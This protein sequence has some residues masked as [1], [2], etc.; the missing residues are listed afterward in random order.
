M[1]FSRSVFVFFTIF[2][3][4]E[5]MAKSNPVPLIN[6]PLVPDSIA[7]GSKGFSLTINGTGFAD[8]AVVNWNGSQRLTQVIS[9]SKVKA[10]IK[11]SDVAKAGTA[12]VT[13]TNSGGATSNVVYFPIRKPA[14]K[15]AF[16]AD[17]KFTATGTIATGDF[18]NDGILDVAVGNGTTIDVYLGKGDGSFRNPIQSSVS[19]V[20]PMFYMVAADVNNDGN[21]DLIVSGGSYVDVAVLLGDGKGSFTQS[22]TYGAVFDDRGY[23]AV[24]DINGDGKLDFVVSGF[25]YAG[26]AFAFLGNGD[27]TFQQVDGNIGLDGPM[28][29]GDFNGDGILDLAGVDID[30]GGPLLVAF[31]NGD[32]TFQKPT[33]YDTGGPANAVVAADVNGDGYLDLITDGV[34]VWLNNGDGTFS[35]GKTF[36]IGG[37]QYGNGPMSIGDF[38]GDGKLDLAVIVFDSNDSPSVDILLGRGHGRFSNPT[39]LSLASRVGY[40]LGLGDFNGTGELALAVSTGSGTVFL[41]SPVSVSPTSLNFGNQEVGGSSKPQDVKLTNIGTFTLPLEGIK[42]IGADP[43]DFSEKNDCGSSLPPN[44][45][46]KISATFKP[47]ATGQRTASLAIEYKGP[48]SPQTVP[49]SGTGISPAVSLTPQHLTYSTQLAGTTSPPQTAT[50][51]NTGDYAVNISKIWTTGAFSETN[52]CPST[53]QVNGSCRIQVQFKPSEKGPAHGKLSVSDDAEGSPQTVALSGTGTVVE[54]SPISVN[55][56][57]QKVST[58]SPAV[59]ITLTNVGTTALSITQITI[60]GADSGDFQQSNNC[61]SGVPAKGH[62]TIKTSFKPLAKGQRKANLA[63]SDDGGGSPQKVPL[64]GTGT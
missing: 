42:I 54:F 36:P 24:G 29:L 44:G 55:F 34:A 9:G 48:G 47:T 64:E 11:A 58:R 23:L 38:N 25:D 16:A 56:G 8:G 46:C 63:V 22:A 52:N 40:F 6:Q 27:G 13:V 28:V 45:N 18:N 57:D 33:V 51:T 3:C 5:L 7:P 15:V 41:Q 4:A 32:G 53:L 12:A 31:G 49:L 39:E 35:L 1:K 10:S 17:P 37:Y 26:S 2:L 21:L 43:K 62:C 19:N 59:P 50:L 30:D 60:T 20:D 61:G 14:A